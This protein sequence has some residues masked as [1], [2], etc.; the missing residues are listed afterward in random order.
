MSRWR[1]NIF[2]AIILAVAGLI[3]YRLVQL[4]HFQHTDFSK[5]AEAQYQNQQ[6]NLARRGTI[7][8]S[9]YS[10]GEKQAVAI[11]KSFPYIYVIPKES[12]DPQV[13][14]EKLFNLIG[15]SLEGGV[16][17]FNKKDDP[18]EIVKTNPTTAEIEAVKILAAKEIS[19][20]YE[21]R[22]YY[23]EN[24]FLSQVIGFLG[25]EGD[26]RVGV[27][28][29]KKKVET[30]S[31]KEKETTSFEVMTRKL[32]F[33]SQLVCSPAPHRIP[34]IARLMEGAEG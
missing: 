7:F 4:A 3:F 29:R 14:A 19:I 12:K 1:I 23:P 11:Q 33:L 9:D 27:D 15:F 30:I 31:E 32:G 22:R 25:Y 20:G 8:V 13:S 10:S 17:I 2:I 6:K 34:A 24:N 26:K 28:L 21:E 18:F 16:K 5:I